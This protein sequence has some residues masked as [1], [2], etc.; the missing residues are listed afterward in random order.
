MV[1]PRPSAWAGVRKRLAPGVP[2]TFDRVERSGETIP[3]R[4]A[5]ARQPPAH[6][7]PARARRKEP[8]GAARSPAFDGLCL[9]L[10]EGH[11]FHRDLTLSMDRSS[12]SG[13]GGEKS[14][15]TRATIATRSLRQ[16]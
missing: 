3:H 4:A 11:V 12:V 14:P 7:R 6:Q 5:I 10:L 1:P 13:R 16:R 9:R 8:D 15:I 2:L